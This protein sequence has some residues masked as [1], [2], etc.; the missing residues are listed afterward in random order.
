MGRAEEKREEK[1]GK[2][3]EWKQNRLLK[4]NSNAKNYVFDRPLI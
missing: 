1:S 3:E 2:E 4:W